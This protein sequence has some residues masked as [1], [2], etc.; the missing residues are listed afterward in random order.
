MIGKGCTK[1]GN[2]GGELLV[3]VHEQKS[4]TIFGF[5]STWLCLSSPAPALTHCV[6]AKKNKRKVHTLALASVYIRG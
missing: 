2:D 5:H 3:D 6:H 4:E 1:N